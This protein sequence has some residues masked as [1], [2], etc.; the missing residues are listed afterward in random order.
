MQNVHQGHRSRLKERFLKD[1]L[2]NFADHNVLE[3][4]LFYAIPQR[5]TNELAHRLLQKFGSLAGVFEAPL[6][7]LRQEP[8]VGDNVATLLR[9]VP[10]LSRRYLEDLGRAQ[11]VLTTEE[12]V[13]DF[14]RPK[15]LGLQKERLYLLCLN[16]AGGIAWAGFLG[17]GTV[18]AILFY[19]REVAERAVRSQAVSVI[20]AH[21]H[22]HGLALPSQMDM[23]VT[24]EVKGILNKL[25]IKLLDHLIFANGDYVS[26]RKSSFLST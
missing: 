19:P 21:N 12:Q 20:L 18:N 23:A 17:E 8:G 7:E 15:F 10:A 13:A 4:L 14:L 5:D 11:T 1:G 3:L 26:L 22:P 6:E 16:N 25:N 24:D 2:D 9:M